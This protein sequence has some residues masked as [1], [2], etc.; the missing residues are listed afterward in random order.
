MISVAL[1]A[2]YLAT[3]ITANTQEKPV[4]PSAGTPVNGGDEIVKCGGINPCKGTSDCKGMSH[5]CKGQNPCRGQGFL[6]TTS[7]QCK[8]KHGFEVK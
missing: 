2:A 5:Q 8:A 3:G 7:A 1:G 4:W 6:V